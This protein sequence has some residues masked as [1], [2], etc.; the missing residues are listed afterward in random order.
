MIVFEC[1]MSRWKKCTVVLNRT[2]RTY[3]TG[4]TQRDGSLRT[5][6][7]CTGH[8]DVL[9]DRKKQAQVS[10]CC[11]SQATHSH[12][13]C[14]IIIHSPCCL[15]QYTFFV[16][17]TAAHDLLSCVPPT[18]FGCYFQPSSGTQHQMVHTAAVYNEWQVLCSLLRGHY[19]KYTI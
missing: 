18:C 10:V 17:P 6:F 19:H 11:D 14:L 1:N 13:K 9:S 4:R 12:A 15:L 7:L 5:E 3:V 2:V 8:I 16:M